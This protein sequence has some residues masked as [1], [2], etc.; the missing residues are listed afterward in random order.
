MVVLSSRLPNLTLAEVD[1]TKPRPAVAP[2]ITHQRQRHFSA[3][4]LERLADRFL[5]GATV[6]ELAAEFACNRQRV[7]RLLRREGIRLRLDGRTPEQ[8]DEAA[9]LYKTGLSLQRIA[10]RFGST[11]RTVRSRLL[12]RGVVMRDTH[13]RVR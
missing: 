11:A 6:Y 3:A 12:K 8:I 2:V 4:E 10:D 1:V 13:G 5:A 9:H 7:A